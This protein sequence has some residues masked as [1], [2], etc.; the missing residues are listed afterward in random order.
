MPNPK[1]YHIDFTKEQSEKVI[2]LCQYESAKINR[3][4]IERMQELQL[5]IQQLYRDKMIKDA[6]L[7]S[8]IS[9]VRSG[10]ES[11]DN[12]K[13]STTSRKKTVN[14]NKASE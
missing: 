2:E 6:E 1:I 13:K 9:A 12:G 7:S 3:E 8:I 4:F 14:E 10:L 5:E 11:K